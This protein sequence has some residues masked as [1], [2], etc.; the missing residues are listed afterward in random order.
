[1]KKLGGVDLPSALEWEDFGQSHGVGT[2]HRLALDGS[3]VTFSG[4]TLEP[5]TLRAGDDH[6]W[7]STAIVTSL[8]TLAASTVST[9][10][11]W[12]GMSIPVRFD[13]TSG[14]AV[15]LAPLYPGAPWY[16]GTISLIKE[17]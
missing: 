6:G 9:T 4:P 10:L 5:I 2:V 3:L 7:F 11:V 15:N 8:L 14:P 1:M 12:G 16:T 13:H 17:G